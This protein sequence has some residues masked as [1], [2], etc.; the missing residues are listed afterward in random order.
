MKIE[1]RFEVRNVDTGELVSEGHN[2]FTNF[3]RQHVCNWLLHNNY[4]DDVLG[5]AVHVAQGGRSIGD[6]IIV[7]Y[8]NI[9]A[10]QVGSSTYTTGIT[11][12]LYPNNNIIDNYM[13]LYSA[14][15]GWSEAGTTYDDSIGTAFFQFSTPITLQ[16]MMFWAR[17]AQQ[18]TYDQG[19]NNAHKFQISTSP[20][21]FVNAQANS[22]WTPQKIDWLESQGWDTST[23]GY[24]NR[25]QMMVRFDYSTYPNRSI[26]NVQSVRIRTINSAWATWGQYYGLW[27]LQANPY[28]NTPSVV[29]IGTGTTTPT[30]ADTALVSE[31]VRQFVRTHKST[32][33]TSQVRYSM[34]VPSLLGNGITFNEVGLFTNPTAGDYIGGSHQASVCT[35]MLARGLF[36]TPWSKTL[37][38]TMDV[39]YILSISNS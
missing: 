35:G 22:S 2:S 7:P 29:A 9:T 1:G 20:D 3:G 11:N 33:S 28:P 21:T 8:S 10:Y 32:G 23:E 27:F 4:A 6:M 39:D 15:G 24:M 18:T 26:A 34:R 17:N 36:N 5:D 19:W 31:S 30:V 13:N 25:R 14:N 37:G 38:Q 12:C 16:A